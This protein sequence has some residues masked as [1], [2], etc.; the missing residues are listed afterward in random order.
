MHF[1]KQSRYQE[2]QNP[3]IHP[4]C[5]CVHAC[6]RMRVCAHAQPSGVNK[7]IE[8]IFSGHFYI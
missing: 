4:L 8:L 3:A 5:M 6:V 7:R 1:N 2:N